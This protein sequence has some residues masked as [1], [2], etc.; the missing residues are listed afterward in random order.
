MVND[1]V[2]VT[3]PFQ[4]HVGHK[5]IGVNGDAFI[6]VFPDVTLKFALANTV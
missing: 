3:L 6:N 5:S 4:S 1:F 2:F